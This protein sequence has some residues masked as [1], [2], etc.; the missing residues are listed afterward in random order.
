MEE[1][2]DLEDSGFPDV[3]KV[4]TGQASC[5]PCFYG[6]VPHCLCFACFFSEFPDLPI[7]SLEKGRFGVNFVVLNNM[8]CR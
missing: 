2:E 7:I 5:L 6:A 1:S 8:V 4:S 3:F